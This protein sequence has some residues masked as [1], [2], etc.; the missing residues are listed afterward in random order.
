MRSFWDLG[1]RAY[2]VIRID[3]FV[4]G[5]TTHS[6]RVSLF[7]VFLTNSAMI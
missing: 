4:I 7:F 1:I 3:S 5:A 2:F 6:T